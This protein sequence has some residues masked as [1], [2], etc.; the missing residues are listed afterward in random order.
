MKK[1]VASLRIELAQY[2]E[3]Q[4]FSQLGSDLDASTRSR[5]NHGEKLMET[6]KQRQY[7]PV[8]MEEQVIIFY[9]AKHGYIADI[10][11]F[12][13]DRFHRNFLSFVKETDPGILDVI[14]ET[15]DFTPETEDRLMDLADKFKETFKPSKTQ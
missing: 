14:R 4:V 12:D 1:V 13:V 15:N 9:V 5:L 11:T 6:I 2:R 8:P 7:S 3:L 10:P